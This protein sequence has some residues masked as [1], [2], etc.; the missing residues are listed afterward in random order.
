MCLRKDGERRGGSVERDGKDEPDNDVFVVAREQRGNRR[1][2]IGR[3][4]GGSGWETG[5][6]EQG[7]KAGLWRRVKTLEVGAW[8]LAVAR[9]LWRWL[10]RQGRSAPST[11]LSD[12]NEEGDREGEG[13]KG[14]SSVGGGRG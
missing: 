10:G 13:E 12:G 9:E 6:A 4:G 7:C 2:C 5:T 8:S 3:L 1:A 11:R 14:G